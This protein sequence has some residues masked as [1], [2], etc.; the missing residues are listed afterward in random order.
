M[1]QLEQMLRGVHPRALRF[2]RGEL[3]EGLSMTNLVVVLGPG[4]SRDLANSKPNLHKP[5]V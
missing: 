3:R 2:A 1:R 5:M 4:K